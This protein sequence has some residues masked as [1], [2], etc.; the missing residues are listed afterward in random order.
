M[1]RHY[2]P[3]PT[4]Y[5]FHSSNALFRGLMGP[6]GSG[7]SVACVAELVSR[8][9]EQAVNAAGVRRTRWAVIR[10][11]YP[12]LRSTT[13]ATWKDWVD[14][15]I[16]PISATSP[17]HAMMRE[18]LADGTS[19]EM[20]V[21][22]LALNS[23][24]H[25]KKL[26]SL[27]LTGAWINE[28]KEVPAGLIVDIIGRT[29]RFPSKGDG[30][31]LTWRGVIADTNPPSTQNW[32]YRLAEQETPEG[33]EFFT[34]PG[35]LVPTKSK[36]GIWTFKPN[37]LA[38]NVEHQQLGYKYWLD[39]VPGSSHERIM[40][41]LC[42]QYASVSSGGKPVWPEYNDHIHAIENLQ[43]MTNVDLL[44]GLDFGLTPAAA[45]GQASP[46]GQLVVLKEVIGRDIGIRQFLRTLLIP[47][48]QEYAGKL[49]GKVI[50]IGDPAG[51][52]RAQTD[53]RTCFD[54][55]KA[56][57]FNI[58][59][60][61]TNAFLPRREA[62]AGYLTRLID[63]RPGLI[64]DKGKC[65][66]LREGLLGEYKYGRISGADDRYREEPEKNMH[67]HISDALQ[68]LALKAQGPI[69]KRSLDKV[70]EIVNTGFG[71]FV[72]G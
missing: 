14:S 32:W 24:D 61:Y 29:G 63:G 45:I 71:G 52:Q 5:L 13:I 70:P 65:T 68:Y 53:E 64:L 4:A 19:V 17:Y 18:R 56:A 43:L 59:S 69:L 26:L 21:W 12:E 39:Q 20:E 16:C 47:A 48:L 49:R 50:V 30:C 38:E 8:S 10:N 54:E 46:R 57:G 40:S 72:R 2:S 31:P 66:L 58:E 15:R 36:A 1:R 3:S 37:P 42:G 22:F 34:Q 6:V 33:F 67:S 60:A 41:Y 62:V 51:S 23:E 44:I 28:A 11:T 27:E 35:A 7:K 9:C 25:T 55:V